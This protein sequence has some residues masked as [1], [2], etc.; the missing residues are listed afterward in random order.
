[1]HRYRVFDVDYHGNKYD[2]GKVVECDPPILDRYGWTVHHGTGVNAVMN[3]FGFNVQ[4]FIN[5]YQCRIIDDKSFAITYRYLD[6]GDKETWILV[7]G[8]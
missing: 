6:G 4:S 8:A 3:L 2:T 1:M 7:R 5:M